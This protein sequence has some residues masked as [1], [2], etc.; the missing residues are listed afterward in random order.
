MTSPEYLLRPLKEYE[1]DRPEGVTIPIRAQYLDN[2]DQFLRKGVDAT[3]WERQK[4][5]YFRV[6][7]TSGSAFFA[8][9]AFGSYAKLPGN[10]RY[11]DSAYSWMLYPDWEQPQL[12]T[13]E[14][15]EGVAVC[16]FTPSLYRKKE[17]EDGHSLWV[18]GQT[19]AITQLQTA[20]FK[21]QH[22]YADLFFIR[23]NE[24]FLHMVEQVAVRMANS[25]VDN[26]RYVSLKKDFE[27]DRRNAIQSLQRSGIRIPS[28]VE[29]QGAIAA[30]VA[31]REAWAKENGYA[32]IIHMRHPYY[33]F[34]DYPSFAKPLTAVTP[35]QRLQAYLTELGVKK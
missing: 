7:L 10:I 11:D 8:W 12:R 6:F 1:T 2:P 33:D 31:K 13:S 34:I 3:E 21:P 23:Y 5:S 20:K 19:V 30:L 15:A 26:L 25:G 18:G 27:Y 17:I 16:G 32:D 9:D 28:E 4:L 14:R 22:R 29:E 35:D 24:L